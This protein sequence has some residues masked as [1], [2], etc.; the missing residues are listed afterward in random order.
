M[1]N[2]MALV[3]AACVAA[4]ALVGSRYMPGEWYLA[5]KKPAWTPPG[6]VF[7]PVWGTLYVMIA[8]A[9]FLVWRAGGAKVPLAIWGLN[10][11]LNAAWSWLFFG[12]HRIDLA[13]V[14]IALVW[15]TIVGFI[16]AAWGHSRLASLLFVPYLAW[17]T[18]ASALNFT[19][20][21]LNG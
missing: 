16:I 17:V 9:G 6:W 15:L 2:L 4:A 18:L 8:A 13:L 11:V 3:F 1:R 21:R 10:L 12:L 5:L 19:I 7:G 20:W 14:D